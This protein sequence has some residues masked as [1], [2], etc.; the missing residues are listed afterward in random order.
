MDRQTTETAQ[1]LASP[2]VVSAFHV[3]QLFNGRGLV[4]CEFLIET[5]ATVHFF[6]AS[7][8]SGQSRRRKG[9]A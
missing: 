5:S 9:V 3:L 1:L 4:R 7:I 8:N 2:G 6:N